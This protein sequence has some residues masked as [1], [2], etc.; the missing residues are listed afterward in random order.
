MFN[1]L[2]KCKNNKQQTDSKGQKK[3]SSKHELPFLKIKVRN[4]SAGGETFCNKASVGNEVGDTNP[5]DSN[6]V[7]LTTIESDIVFEKWART[8]TAGVWGDW[9][10][11]EELEAGEAYQ[12]KVVAKNVGTTTVENVIVT[13][14]LD[15]NLTYISTEN[16][17]VTHDGINPG[18]IVTLDFGDI[19]AG[20]TAEKIFTVQLSSA[21]G[22]DVSIPNS[23]FDNK[24]YCDS[25]KDGTVDPGKEYSCSTVHTIKPANPTDSLEIVKQSKTERTKPL[26]L[27]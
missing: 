27:S 1:D 10:K 17:G 23:I 18:G 21:V 7:C 25:D 13:D 3:R 5:V 26:W 12:Y 16:T 20:I 22:S 9:N 11:G 6:E 4:V 15:A 2:L 19:I 24:D 8:K 14:L